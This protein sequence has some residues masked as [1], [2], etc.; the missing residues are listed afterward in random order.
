VVL[1]EQLAGSIRTHQ[2]EI[3]QH[4]Q[5]SLAQNSG[6]HGPGDNGVAPVEE[7]R[8]TYSKPCAKKLHQDPNG[9]DEEMLSSIEAVM[10]DVVTPQS[11]RRNSPSIGDISLE[12]DD[13]ATLLDFEKSAEMQQ[14]AGDN[15]Q[16]SNATA[17]AQIPFDQSQMQILPVE[18]QEAVQGVAMV[19]MDRDVAQTPWASGAEQ[20]YI[21]IQVVGSKQTRNIVC[22][23]CD[24]VGKYKKSCGTGHVCQKGI[25]FSQKGLSSC[26]GATSLNK[27]VYACGYCGQR[28]VSSA[29]VGTK[30]VKIR[31]D[32]RGLGKDH[33]A[34]MHV[35]WY[36]VHDAEL[37]V[38]PVAPTV[39]AMDEDLNVIRRRFS[40]DTV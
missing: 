8:G 16:P 17:A 15:T 32:C 18:Q 35:K 29:S 31:C 12:F 19:E 39:N 34:K 10:K 5:S 9:M 26:P 3:Q 23:C 13:Y 22:Q 37:G 11:A 27:A 24:A 28:K 33:M 38:A 4:E 30:G 25:C 6:V 21:P 2:S 36:R 1:C 7:R 40:D 20:K 14:H